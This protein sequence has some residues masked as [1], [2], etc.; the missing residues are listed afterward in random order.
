MAIVETINANWERISGKELS[1]QSILTSRTKETLIDV[2]IDCCDTYC[3]G[4][5]TVDLS[6]GG[7]ISTIL[8]A[9]VIQV[10]NQLQA[11][12]T[13]AACDAAATGTV[14]FHDEGG[15]CTTALAEIAC[16]S[17]L[18]QCITFKVHVIGF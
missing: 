3:T 14:I 18:I 4:G 13:P 7:R 17:C 8:T 11:V 2:A 9:D 6:A 12:Y 15:A 10:S 1:R 16:G 5:I